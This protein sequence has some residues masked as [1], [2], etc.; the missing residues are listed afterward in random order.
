MTDVRALLERAIA[1]EQRGEREAARALYDRV[2]AVAPEHPGALLKLALFDQAAGDTQSAHARL[3]RALRAAR[4]SRL[5]TAPIHLAYAE[6]H[7]HGNDW[8]A[9]RA[10]YEQALAE[11]PGHPAATFGLGQLALRE[12]DAREAI[13]RFR[14]VLARQ[15]DS[16]PARAQLANALLAQGAAAEAAA[17]LAPAIDA[18]PASAP[19]RLLAASIALRRSDFAGAIDHCRAG[20]DAVPGHGGLLT[21]LGHALRATG[22]A[23]GAAAAFGEAAAAAPDDA[24]AWLASGNACMEAELARVDV[25]RRAATTAT[26]T[27]LLA[28]ALA[29][30]DRAAAL[31]PKAVAAQAH[32]AM[33]A[34]YA[35]DW[36]RASAALQA[37]GALHAAD[38]ASFACSPMMAVA[39]LSDAAA[40]KDGI[41]GWVRHSL[42][43]AQAPAVIARRGDRLRVGYLSTDF[44]D[45]ATAHLAAGMFE[46]HDGA[47]FDT[48]AYAADRDDGSAMRRRLR[49]AFAHWRD[50]RAVPDG[51]AAKLIRDD[52]LDVLVDLKGHTHGTRIA[53]LAE[54]PAPVQ[55]HYL[56]FPGTL[57]YGAVDGFVA[58]AIVAPHGSETEF[59]E[60]LLRLP[61]CYQVNDAR[62]P[63]PE[64][65]ARSAAG[66]PDN[67][68]V[69]ACFN[70]AYK[71]TEP[72]VAAWLAAL[73][74]QPGAVLW[75]T[76]PHA[77]ARHNLRSFAER[78]GVA[79]ERIVFAPVVP[80]VAHIARLRCADLALDVLPY[81]SHTTGS[82]ALWAGV[83]LLTCRGTTFAGRVGASLCHA[84][85][86]PELVTESVADYAQQLQRLCA[87]RSRLAHYRLHLASGRTRLP[88][89]DTAAFTRAFE[90][91]LEDAANGKC[92]ERAPSSH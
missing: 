40:L 64:A 12:G 10:A 56:G 49:Q 76:V 41:A 47:R 27:D 43:P 92:S 79:P 9:A 84:V 83:P 71:L 16:V 58:D 61:V 63:L 13:E 21:A 87:D 55:I 8:M 53:L 91:M 14:A 36:P 37:L 54:R 86:L 20:L 82:D 29:A 67:A 38:P 19:L 31:R 65:A 42:P 22:A 90:R 70:Q 4:S 32:L 77:L 66:L 39:L 35:C 23:D 52:A 34:R 46:W 59:T 3:D 81:G 68:L 48:F 60:A 7:E 26:A 44:H 57:A 78:A 89:F 17:E 6:L 2:L 62:R 85:E 69:L 18:I 30:F 25:A 5:A 50:I 51:D 88:L 1:N 45:H 15:P 80:Q 24:A 11:V 73:R 75:L 72:F 33:A 74:G 28:D